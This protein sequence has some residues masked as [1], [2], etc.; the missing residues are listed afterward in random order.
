MLDA[1]LHICGARAGAGCDIQLQVARR[2]GSA[3]HQLNAAGELRSVG[4][5]GHKQLLGSVLPRLA[6]YEAL[7]PTL[8]PQLIALSAATDD[9]CCC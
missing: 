1:G 8:V 3:S 2:L 9:R 4:D 7:P 6:Q 5:K